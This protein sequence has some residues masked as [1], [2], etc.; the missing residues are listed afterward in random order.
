MKKNQLIPV[1]LLF[2]GLAA[3][4]FT[5]AAGVKLRLKPQQGETNTITSNATSTTRIGD[6]GLSISSNQTVKTRQ[7]FTAKTVSGNKVVIN[8]QID[9]I[10][11][12]MSMM[13]MNIEYDSEHPDETNPLIADQAEEFEKN[14][15]KPFSMTYDAT[16]KT[17]SNKND[18]PMSQLSSVIIPLPKE[19]LN[20]GS[21]WSSEKKQEV[22]G[23]Q[24]KANMEYTVTA[25]STTSVEVNFTGHVKAKDASG[26]FTGTA[27]IAPQTGMTTKSTTRSNISMSIRDH[28]RTSP[29]SMS[30]V[31]TIEVK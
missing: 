2:I 8:S 9:A 4:S 16:G 30:T 3:L 1:L 12:T 14:L 17:V 28:G 10:K 19:E 5:T 29:V 20:V 15:N 26:T 7:S 24:V 31:T 13:S 23:M 6:Q 27:S 18:L 21:K 22:N 11:M 25:I